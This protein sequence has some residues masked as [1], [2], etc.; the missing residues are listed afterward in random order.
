MPHFMATCSASC[1]KEHTCLLCKTVF[2]YRMWRTERVAGISL[3][4]AEKSA[5][6]YVEWLFKNKC[7]F[8]ACPVC[9]LYQ[10]EMIVGSRCAA[11]GWTVG[12]STCSMIGL[13]WLVLEK[14]A[15]MQTA[16]I[17]ALI[18]AII[19]FLF[20]VVWASPN[21]NHK[22]E[23]NLK[24]AREEV[25]RGML[26]IVEAGIRPAQSGVSMFRFGPVKVIAAVLVSVLPLIAAEMVRGF[27]GWKVNPGWSP[28]IAG[29]GDSPRFYMTSR[30][31][32]QGKWAG[33][34]QALLKN[35]K[36]FNLNENAITAVARGKDWDDVIYTKSDEWDGTAQIYVELQL[37]PSLD[38]LA[39][40]RLQF[41]L[42]V[43]AEYPVIQSHSKFFNDRVYVGQSTSLVL[44]SPRAGK[45]YWRTWLV[46]HI[47]GTLSLTL[48][49]L[50]LCQQAKKMTTGF[51]SRVIPILEG[52]TGGEASG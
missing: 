48:I 28:P 8:H 4:A 3:E 30:T 11:H 26:N 32:I 33:K 17:G 24:R 25:A 6:T 44:A 16:I 45:V 34:A 46:G 35:A 5:R 14:Y 23:L 15:E 39:N 31:S 42:E 7:D 51:P 50:Y 18:V 47:V 49:G 40:K 27:S 41:D 37:N 36:S 38:Q 21:P 10:P 12:I 1:F 52:G 9:G 22:L 43:D 19:A 2:R 20:H 13:L 29:P